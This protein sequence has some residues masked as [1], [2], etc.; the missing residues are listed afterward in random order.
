MLKLWEFD[1]IPQTHMKGDTVSFRET[2]VENV[3][4]HFC[5]LI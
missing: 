5:L 4:F 1:I 3:N 2:F